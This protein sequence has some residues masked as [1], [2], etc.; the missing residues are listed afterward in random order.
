MNTVCFIAPLS[1]PKR[2]TRL[3][4]MIS[5]FQERNCNVSFVGWD[6][7]AGEG[8]ANGSDNVS[9][10]WIL[11]GGGYQSKLARLMYPIWMLVVF[12]YVLRNR[13]E[14]NYFCLGWETAFPALLAAWFTGAKIVFDDA[15]RFSL[16]LRLPPLINRLLVYLEKWAS[17]KALIH[18]IPGW[19]RYEWRGQNMLILRNTPSSLDFKNANERPCEIRAPAG[20]LVLYANGWLGQTRGAGIFLRLLNLAQDRNLNVYMLVAG[21][22]DSE[23][24]FALVSHPL[25]QF[26]GELPQAEALALYKH[27][28]VAL[29]YYDPTVLIN[30][31]AESNKWGDCVFFRKP[32]IVNSE[33][34]TASQ[35]VNCGAAFSVAYDDVEGLYFLLS[36][37]FHDFLKI[38]YAEKSLGAVASDFPVFDEQLIR[39]LNIFE[40]GYDAAVS[41]I[42]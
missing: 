9:A 26:F 12:F 29:T 8:K 17:K 25:V 4:K 38:E 36:E 35:F 28:D 20:A 34:E 18:L 2:R 41:S 7:I 21:R 3:A 40:R 5:F 13:N 33:V 23:D 16:I 10:R 39:I 42:N 1:S 27:C 37:L 22:V 30:R 24:G 15:D 11:R 32:F 19:S 14:K 6:R 31:K